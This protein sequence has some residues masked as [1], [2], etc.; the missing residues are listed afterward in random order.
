MKILFLGGTLFLGY[1]TVQAALDR[2]HEVTLFNRGKSN[3][4]AFDDAVEYIVGDR[5]PQDPSGSGGLEELQGTREW[6]AV[7]DVNGYLPRLV[8]ASVELLADRCAHYLFVSTISVYSGPIPRGLTEDG[9]HLTM[10]DP[11]DEEVMAN[12]GELKSLCET[13]IHNYVADKATIVRP[14]IVAGPR[15]YTDRFTYWVREAARQEELLLSPG[16]SEDPFQV[17]D[18]RDIGKWLIHLLETKTLGTFNACGPSNT[19]TVGE[20]VDACIEGTGSTAK[21]EW[22]PWKF[23]EEAGVAPWSD[24][25]LCLPTD[26]ESSLIRTVDSSKAYAAGLVIRPL[27]NTARDTWE[28]L[29]E[30]LLKQKKR[31]L[32][33]GMTTERSDAVMFSWRASKGQ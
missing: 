21:A 12:Y 32:S 13:E 9:P 11:I 29:E 8:K 7:L 31:E 15:D 24:L 30:D 22:V 27:A 25:P 28:W 16:R 26:H 4:R 20:L 33:T 14:G 5:D 1:H 18:A 10:D 3:A 6:D 17:I 19:C 2:G 23:L